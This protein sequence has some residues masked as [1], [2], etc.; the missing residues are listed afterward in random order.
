[1]LWEG[2]KNDKKMLLQFFKQGLSK[3]K[4]GYTQDLVKKA[5]FL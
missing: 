1:M 5:V 3:L 2:E 4:K